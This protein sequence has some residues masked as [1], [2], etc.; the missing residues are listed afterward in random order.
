VRAIFIGP[1]IR[2]CKQAVLV[3]RNELDLYAHSQ[4][5]INENA[6]KVIGAKE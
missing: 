1:A 4:P 6:A 2:D 5:D 3:L